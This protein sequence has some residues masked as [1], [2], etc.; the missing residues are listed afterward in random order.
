M[1]PFSTFNYL[2]SLGIEGSLA[3]NIQERTNPVFM[4]FLKQDNSN[5]NL[6]KVIE[7]KPD[8][9]ATITDSRLCGIVQVKWVWSLNK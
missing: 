7:A 1:L 5:Y 2:M 9:E 4:C 3:A 8:S 6:T